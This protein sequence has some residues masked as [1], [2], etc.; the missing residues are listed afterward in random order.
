MD[1]VGTGAGSGLGMGRPVDWQRMFL[2]VR[3]AGLLP[4]Y[5]AGQVMCGRVAGALPVAGRGATER[6]LGSGS[7]GF[8]RAER[9]GG[10]IRAV[11]VVE[12]VEEGSA[13]ETTLVDLAAGMGALDLDGAEAVGADG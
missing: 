10:R 9:A 2:Q 13:G 3:C 6:Q 12:G 5:L 7:F 1:R 8:G 4:R 11:A